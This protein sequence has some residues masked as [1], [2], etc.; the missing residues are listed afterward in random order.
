MA[1]SPSFTLNAGTYASRNPT[2]V[3]TN[4]DLTLGGS[5]YLSMGGTN[6]PGV[7]LDGSPEPPTLV[8]TRGG[9]WVVPGSQTLNVQ[10]SVTATAQSQPFT[11]ATIFISYA[12]SG[13][14]TGTTVFTLTFKAGDTVLLSDFPETTTFYDTAGSDWKVTENYGSLSVQSG[15]DGLQLTSFSVLCVQ[16]SFSNI[17]AAES[18]TI[19]FDLPTGILRTNIGLQAVAFT[20]EAT[21]PTVPLSPS[22]SGIGN[23]TV[24]RSGVVDSSTTLRRSAV[25]LNYTGASLYASAGLTS[26]VN[27][28]TVTT[29]STGSTSA[30]CWTSALPDISIAQEVMS[31]NDAVVSFP[32]ASF[33]T[34]GSALVT[35]YFTTIVGP[36][37]NRVPNSCPILLSTS[38][39]GSTEVPMTFGVLGSAL[40]YRNW[41]LSTTETGYLLTEFTGATTGDPNSLFWV[42]LDVV[43]PDG[44]DTI[45][46]QFPSSFASMNVGLQSITIDPKSS[47]LIAAAPYNEAPSILV[48]SVGVSPLNTRIDLASRAAISPFTFYACSGVGATTSKMTVTTIVSASLSSWESSNPNIDMRD[49]LGTTFSVSFASGYPTSPFTFATLFLSTTQN[50]ASFLSADLSVVVNGTPVTI[51]QSAI[52]QPPSSWACVFDSSDTTKL[53]VDTLEYDVTNL[54]WIQL[55]L[56]NLSTTDLVS[57]TTTPTLTVEGQPYAGM[58]AVVMSTGVT[59]APACF[60]ANTLI[61]CADGVRRPVRSLTSPVDVLAACPDGGPDAVVRVDVYTR[62]MMV[63]SERVGLVA[64]GVWVTKDHTVSFGPSWDARD[65]DKDSEGGGGGKER[66]SHIKAPDVIMGGKFEGKRSWIAGTLPDFEAEFC[67]DNLYQ[68]VPLH[69]GHRRFAVYVGQATAD[70]VAEFYRSPASTLCAINQYWKVE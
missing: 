14:S 52:V 62:S 64:P 65:K 1:T 29:P 70:C 55:Q 28:I 69:E 44:A 45:K 32:A 5:A 7:S 68:L 67:I 12:G 34:A 27:G 18:L 23:V 30:L 42:Q 46:V 51:N 31:N 54:L 21:A 59:P 56:R 20:T 24:S 22:F 66:P 57:I 50:P 35:L 43:I 40:I 13:S 10:G 3:Q 11:F 60:G 37:S 38:S 8:P 36:R 9:A 39:A 47:A 15:Q 4:V 19:D 41:Q 58:Q 6:N 53:T 16:I 26:S 25:N 61:L 17:A 63:A 49:S 2:L 48:F 33:A